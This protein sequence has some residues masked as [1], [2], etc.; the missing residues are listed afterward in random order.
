MF[1]QD[2]QIRPKKDTSGSEYNKPFSS[3]LT[4]TLFDKMKKL[5]AEK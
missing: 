5:S 2:I 1:T 3:K 4:K